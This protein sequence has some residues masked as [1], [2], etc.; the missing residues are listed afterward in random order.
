MKEPTKLIHSSRPN[1]VPDHPVNPPIER[2]STILFSDYDA[3]LDGKRSIR[4]GRLGTSTHRQLEDIVTELECGVATHLAPSGL[5]A[6][7]AAILAFVQTG[8]HVLMAD[9]VYDPTR[10]FADGF[11]KRFG[12]E[13]TFFDPMIGDRITE[14]LR[15]NTKVIYTEAP[16]SLTF[17]VGDITALATARNQDDVTVIVDNTWSAGVYYKPLSLGA[18][19][20][21]QAGTKY[22]AGHSDCLIGTITSASE[23]TANAVFRSLLRIG[24]SVSADDAY[25]TLRGIRTLTTRLKQHETN[26]TIL[27][28]WLTNHDDVK[29]VLYPAL[30]TCV[31][32]ANWKQHFTGSSGL[33]S[34]ILKR[35]HERALRAFHDALRLFGMGY[36]WGGYES[37][38]IP[39]D[40][41][42]IRTATRWQETGPLLRLHAGLEDPEDLIYDLENAFNVM[43][44]VKLID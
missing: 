9:G 17:E 22:L 15:P 34:I 36:S 11:L 23:Q 19:V 44:A 28:E 24:S 5:Q 20:S 4:Y 40:P 7:I 25:L 27:C 2:A 13:T 18:D 3:F 32:H 10:K 31:G 38:C 37:L 26:A 42:P 43:A 41:K 12:V 8:D 21:I 16:S 39:C 14:L 30:S 6:C 29:T 33:F 35:N 1:G